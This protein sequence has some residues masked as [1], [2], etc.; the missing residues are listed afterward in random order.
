MSEKI[1]GNRKT[2]M[3]VAIVVLVTAIGGYLL[4]NAGLLGGNSCSALLRR[5]NG[6]KGT[7]DYTIMNEVFPL[8][9]EKDCSFD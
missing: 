4:F 3:V 8:M 6:A 1:A 9:M 5:Y 7:E 2:L